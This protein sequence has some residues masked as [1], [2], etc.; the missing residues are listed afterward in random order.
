MAVRLARL[1]GTRA[2]APALLALR[3]LGA[4]MVETCNPCLRVPMK[5]Y[6]PPLGITRQEAARAYLQHGTFEDAAGALGC[7]ESNVQRHVHRT[8]TRVRRSTHAFKHVRTPQGVIVR[9]RLEA[10]EFPT[11]RVPRPTR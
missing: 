2:T 7:S 3:R 4:K 9:V 5:P 1:H 8:T 11:D 10:D 6:Y